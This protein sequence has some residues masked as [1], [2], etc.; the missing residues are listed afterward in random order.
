MKE[1]VGGA[2]LAARSVAGPALLMAGLTVL[3]ARQGRPAG[4]VALVWGAMV[5]E[6][7]LTRTCSVNGLIG[8]DTAGPRSGVAS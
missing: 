5:T 3:G 2:E 8:R 6:T 1:N 7:A 4:L